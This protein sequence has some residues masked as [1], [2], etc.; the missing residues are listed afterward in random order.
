M[1]I[2]S[3][4]ETDQ[5]KWYNPTLRSRESI[6]RAFLQ[7]VNITERTID[8]YWIDYQCQLIRYAEIEPNGLVNLNTYRTHP[9]IFCDQRTGLKMHVN[10]QEVFWPES[11]AAT[12]LVTRTKIE[13]HYPVQNL[14][15][16]A[17]WKIVL[18]IQS[19]E[20]LERLEI[21]RILLRDLKVIYKNYLEY[22]SKN[23]LREN[24]RRDE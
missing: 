23:R 2:H 18:H 19:D 8:V 22:I 13:I 4:S 1:N 9:W 14:K 15:T 12:R 11:W 5:P 16:I 7:L 17:L 24:V 10:H 6:N 21:P 20:Q 3:A